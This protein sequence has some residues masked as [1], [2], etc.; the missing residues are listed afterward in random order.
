M[1]ATTGLGAVPWELPEFGCDADTLDQLQAD[2][3]RACPSATCR[4]MAG[5]AG[6]GARTTWSAASRA[7]PRGV[8]KGY[9]G[10]ARDVTDV[11]ARQALAATETRYQELFT[12]IPTPLV[13]HRGA[14]SSTPTRRRWPCSA[15]PTCR[16]MLGQDLLAIYESGDSRE[17][18]RRRVE[19]CSRWAPARRCR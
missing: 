12:R 19:S 9:W 5:R 8:F 15:T 3:R 11:H 1:G 7:S 17:R 16:P 2:L 10:V 4:C 18:A 13:L 6:A 14:A